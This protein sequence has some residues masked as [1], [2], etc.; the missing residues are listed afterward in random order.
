M[1]SF[2]PKGQSSIRNVLGGDTEHQIAAIWGFIK[3][4]KGLPNRFPNH[5]SDRFELVPQT[6]PIIQRAFFEKTGT[7]AILVGFPGEI[8]LAYDGMKSQLS[9]VWRGRFFDTYGTWFSRFV[10]FEKPLSSEVYPV[11][12]TGLETARFRGY[13]IGP[14]GNPTFL[15]SRANQNIQDSYRA[16]DG[17]FVRMVKWD[18]GIS[19]PVAHPAGVRLETITGER[20]IKYIYSWK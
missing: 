16:E 9:L 3:E 4:G 6:T 11:N 8:H 14:R 12:N 17:K 19:P 7:K 5:R 15:S 18:Q 1:P 20:S 13:T 10:P 2:W